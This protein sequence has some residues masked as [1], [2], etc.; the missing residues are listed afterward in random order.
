[1]AQFRDWCHFRLRAVVIGLE[2][3]DCGVNSRTAYDIFILE[4]RNGIY[5]RRFS[6]LEGVSM[7]IQQIFKP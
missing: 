4:V 7:R 6:H 3:F 1:M 2:H 5:F